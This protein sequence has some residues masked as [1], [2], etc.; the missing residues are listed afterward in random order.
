MDNYIDELEKELK[1]NKD[2]NLVV[3]G[4]LPFGIKG[5]RLVGS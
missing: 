2:V 3:W 4:G 5:S 1:E